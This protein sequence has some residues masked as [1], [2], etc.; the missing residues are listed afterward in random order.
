MVMNISGRK[1]LDIYFII[2]KYGLHIGPGV[3]SASNRN[4]NQEYSLRVKAAGA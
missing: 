2:G 1:D 4:E 3:D